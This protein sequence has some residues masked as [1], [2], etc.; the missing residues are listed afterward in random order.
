[1]FVGEGNQDKNVVA[2]Y[3]GMADQN[4]NPAAHSH[5]QVVALEEPLVGPSLKVVGLGNLA[6]DILQTLLDF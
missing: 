5:N 3:T 6:V 2:R 1:M 4:K